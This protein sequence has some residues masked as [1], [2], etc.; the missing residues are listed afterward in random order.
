MSTYLSIFGERGYVD[1]GREKW[2]TW[3]IQVQFQT[4]LF[5]KCALVSKMVVLLNMFL[6]DNDADETKIGSYNKR[7]YIYIIPKLAVQLRI[8]GLHNKTTLLFIHSLI[9]TFTAPVNISSSG[10]VFIYRKN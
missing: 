4:H 7:V 2:D 6:W 10:R 9:L 8:T 3:T 1:I 5:C